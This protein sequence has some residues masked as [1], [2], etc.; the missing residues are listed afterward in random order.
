MLLLVVIRETEFSS[1]DRFY[2]DDDE[3]VGGAHSAYE[4]DLITDY[5]TDLNQ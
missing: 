3:Q 2:D 1:L 5:D 4:F